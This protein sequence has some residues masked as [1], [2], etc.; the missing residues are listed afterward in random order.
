[1]V[2]RWPCV[3]RVVIVAKGVYDRSVLLCSRSI[4]VKQT[5]TEEKGGE[6]ER[7][8]ASYLCPVKVTSDHPNPP[9][10]RPL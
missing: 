7:K 4:S 3:D 1:M 10:S 9:T 5:R 2:D 8:G 6:R